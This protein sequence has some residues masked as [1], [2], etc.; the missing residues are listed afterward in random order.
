MGVPKE[1]GYTKDHEWAKKDGELVTVGI[2]DYAQDQ[3]G[4][5]VFLELPTVGKSFK[6]GD[7]IAVVES[8]KAASDIYA[9]V[10]GEVVEI[11]KDAAGSPELINSDP[12]AKAWLVKLKPSNVSELSNLLSSDAYD[13]LVVELNG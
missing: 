4:D 2:T 3:L 8:V 11:N 13:K 5:V 7:S 6:K 12:F 1:C 9:P 10:S